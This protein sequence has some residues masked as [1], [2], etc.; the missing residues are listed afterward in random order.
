MSE[1]DG[2]VIATRRCRNQK[3]STANLQNGKQSNA[4]QRPVNGDKEAWK[5]YWK[6]Q[7]QE[8]R[9]EPEIDAERQKYLA[10]RRGITPDIEQGIYPFKDIKLSR[11]D[12]EWLLATHDDGRGPVEWSDEKD[13]HERR[14]LDLRGADLRRVNLNNLPLTHL[15]GGLDQE[16]RDLATV[17]QGEM[18]AI[19]LEGAS[20]RRA[21]L[22]RAI[23]SWAHLE[24][25]NLSRVHLERANLYGAHLEKTDLTQAHLEGVYLLRSTLGDEHGIG[26]R[27]LNVRWGD[28]NHAVVQW[29]QV[30]M[31][32]D[33]YEATR[34]MQSAREID[35]PKLLEEYEQAVI[36]NRQ[37]SIVLL[38]Q[39]LN[40]DA[41]RFAYRAQVVQ[42]KVF[43]YQ[44]FRS[45]GRYLFSLFLALLT[46]YGYK[47]TRSFIA[48]AVVISVFAIIYFLLGSHLAW[49]EA[50]VISMTAFHGRGFFP[51]QFK[52]GDP[53]ALVAAIEAFVGLLIEVTFIATLTQRLFGK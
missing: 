6:S 10:E 24:Q 35:R 41:A 13:V 37:L 4:A 32:T 38:S 47:P 16:E 49:N 11:A 21:R 30:K 14:G 19:H 12:V 1:Q 31:L 50:I 46:G 39:G 27:L 3:T 53:Q 23:F 45:F 18:A 33:E 8:W 2:T 5:A 43:L 28:A 15:Y 34:K 51:E 42:R 25:A 26:P 29:S 44:G 48:Y 9:T 7:G 20:L 40:E 22:E 17:E 52:P 36:A